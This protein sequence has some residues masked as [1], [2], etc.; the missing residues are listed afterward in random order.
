MWNPDLYQKAIKF[1]AE[2]HGDQKIPGSNLPYVV[3]LSNVCMETV[4]AMVHSKQGDFDLAM[5]CALLHD[6]IEDTAIS[7]DEVFALFGEKV[8]MGVQALTKNKYLPKSEQMADSLQ[9]ILTQ[10]REV[11]IVKMADRIS[12]LQRPPHY[13]SKEKRLAYQL[14]AQ[15][16]LDQLGG[17]N[18]YLEERLE[19]KIESYVLFIN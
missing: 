1:A 16:I 19:Q 14:E 9:R 2:A 3:H 10:S 4:A 6:T 5:Q 11:R 15:L 12:N 13:W 18:V 17:V 7:Y 8:A